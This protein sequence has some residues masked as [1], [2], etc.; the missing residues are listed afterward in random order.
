MQKDWANVGKVIEM[1]ASVCVHGSRKWNVRMCSH[2][3]GRERDESSRM[4][5]LFDSTKS[6]MMTLSQKACN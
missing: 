3:S 5:D 6:K 4:G 1:C 2:G